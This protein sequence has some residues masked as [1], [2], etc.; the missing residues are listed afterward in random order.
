MANGW[1][2]AASR[3][4]KSNSYVSAWRAGAMRFSDCP[5]ALANHDL[6]VIDLRQNDNIFNLDSPEAGT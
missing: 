4:E 5:V 6:W 3:S 1:P 2:F